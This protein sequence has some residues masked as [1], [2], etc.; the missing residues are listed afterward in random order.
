MA[1]VVGEGPASE[2]ELLGL[3]RPC[4]DEVLKIW[5]V[6]KAVGNVKNTGRQL[7][8]RPNAGPAY[9]RYSYFIPESSSH[10]G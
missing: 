3:L 10:A 6:G 8:G 7:R 4:A 2:D 9:L 5:P 1:E